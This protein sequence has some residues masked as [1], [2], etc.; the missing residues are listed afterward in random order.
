VS[1]RHLTA[2]EAAKLMQCPL[3]Q[4][5]NA[6]SCHCDLETQREAFLALPDSAAP[7]T[8]LDASEPT[9]DPEP[10]PL[11]ERSQRGAQ[12]PSLAEPEP[13][14]QGQKKDAGKLPLELLPTRPLEAVAAVLA[15]GARKYRAN[16]WRA[17][18]AYSRVYAAVLRHM[19]AW[20]R[21]EDNDRET[22]LPHLAHAMCELA[23]LLDYHLRPGGPGALDD[24]IDN[25]ATRES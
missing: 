19:W 5:P 20:W 25:D 18:I 21:G 4:A 11:T 1:E 22:G 2:F 9:P 14:D 23:F 16:G 10:V 24:R 8:R 6:W 15:F 13:A 17:G 12:A 3:C 7:E